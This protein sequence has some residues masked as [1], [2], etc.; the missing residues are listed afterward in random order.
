ML[1]QTCFTVHMFLIG[2]ATALTGKLKHASY[3]TATA[4]V[5]FMFTWRT[6]VQKT[7]SIIVH[8]VL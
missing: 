1:W 5:T 4:C 2:T 8:T 3:E 7:E 6:A